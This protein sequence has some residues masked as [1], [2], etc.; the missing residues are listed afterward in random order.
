MADTQLDNIYFI[1]K[2]PHQ[3]VFEHCAAVVHHGGAGTSHASTRAGC[4]SIVVPFMDEQLYWAKQ[5][6]ALGLAGKPLPAKKVTA[7]SLATGIRAVIASIVM[8]EKAQ[9]ARLMMQ[10]DQGVAKAL[11]L[12]TESLKI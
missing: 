9:Q 6:Q 1:G 11:Q 3:R 4:P 7:M 2:H 12:I 10:K 8:T 5:L